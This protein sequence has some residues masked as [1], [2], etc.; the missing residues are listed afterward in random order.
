MG[1]NKLDTN[2][3]FE[4]LNMIIEKL[5]IELPNKNIFIVLKDPENDKQLSDVM[6]F[7]GEENLNKGYKKYFNKL[8]KPYK[9]TRVLMT[10][11]ETKSR[12]DFAVL[13]L[14]DQLGKNTIIVSRDR[15]SDIKET[16][17]DNTKIKFVIYGLNAS[18][19][20][21]LL[22]KPFTHI[23]NASRNNLV[24]YSFSKKYSTAFYNKKK[25]KKSIAS[26]YVLLFNMK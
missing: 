3:Y 26:E 24:G 21:K 18:K 1:N 23:N 17:Q 12:D 5:N 8:L 2:K 7:L 16:N 22:N 9:K 19:Y 6:Q 4:L 10:Y 25:N 20:N 13:W 11:G 14:S 15:Y